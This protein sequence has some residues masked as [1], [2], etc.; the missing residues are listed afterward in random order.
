VF[1][2]VVAVVFQNVFHSEI[3]Q[4]NIF[5]IIFKILFLTSVHQNDLRIPKKNINLK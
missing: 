2:N 1:G 4:N 3:Y 5:I